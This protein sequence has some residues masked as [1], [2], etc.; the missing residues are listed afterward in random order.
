MSSFPCLV[1]F[2][3]PAGEVRYSLGDPL[4]DRYLEFVAGVDRRSNH[5]EALAFRDELLKWNRPPTSSHGPDRWSS[6]SC[7][8]RQVG[9]EPQR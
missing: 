4:V 2:A 9:T 5:L 8:G 6:R 1:R 7:R 3:S